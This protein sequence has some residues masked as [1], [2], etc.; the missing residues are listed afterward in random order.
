MPSEYTPNRRR[1]SR[2]RSRP[3]TAFAPPPAPVVETQ[4]DIS[5]LQRYLAMGARCVGA[6]A[7]IG[8]WPGAIG[9]GLGETAAQMIERETMD[10]SKLD[11]KSIAAEAAVGAVGG[12][13]AKLL[14]SLLS[15]PAQAAA[16]GALTG[17]AA[18]VIRHGFEEGDINPLN[19][20]GEVATSGAISGATGGALAG[21]AKY[22][23]LAGKPQPKVPTYRVETTAVPGGQVL[24]AGGKG[25]IP[26][27]TTPLTIQGTGIPTTVTQAAE[28]AAGRL[29]YAGM[30]S[31]TK[32]QERMIAAEQKAAADAERLDTIRQA[33]LEA[34]VEP[35]PPA[36]GESLSAPTP[37]GGTEE[38]KRKPLD[39]PQTHNSP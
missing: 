19:Y 10:P 13:Y 18:P 14:G 7:G 16:M 9:G 29:P 24:K 35:Q 15:R 8:F 2:P 3:S 20:P 32:A 6:L 26:S 17:A 34:G 31:I 27:S 39:P 11:P 38:R 36:F 23:G 1:R 5:K 37:E 4:P 22:L 21:L 30:P 25:I 33:R 28:S 12:K